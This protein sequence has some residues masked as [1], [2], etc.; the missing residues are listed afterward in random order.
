MVDYS[1]FNTIEGASDSDD[2]QKTTVDPDRAEAWL[3]KYD[4]TLRKRDAKLKNPIPGDATWLTPTERRRLMRHASPGPTGAL[5]AGEQLPSDLKDSSEVP[6]AILHLKDPWPSVDAAQLYA[7]ARVAK[8]LDKDV[9]R[10]AAG[11]PR[12]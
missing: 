5:F 12:I 7:H 9:L 6:A 1:K 2:D 11:G 8:K 10:A 3:R 4:A